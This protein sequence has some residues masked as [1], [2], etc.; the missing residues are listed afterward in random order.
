[1]DDTTDTADSDLNETN[2]NIIYVDREETKRKEFISP[3]QIA[4]KKSKPTEDPRLTDAYSVMTA[5][6]GNISAQSKDGCSAYTEHIAFKLRSYSS[7]TRAVVEHHINNIIFNADMGLY[8]QPNNVQLPTTPTNSVG[9]YSSSASSPVLSPAANTYQIPRTTTGYN[10]SA[11]SSPSV[12]QS[13]LISPTGNQV[14]IPAA[15]VYYPTTATTDLTRLDTGS[16]DNL[17]NN[18]VSYFTNYRN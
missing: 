8:A 1:M 5:L 10:S 13:P 12:T 7:Y 14:N 6:K 9:D 16:T 18:L 11:A 15:D 17:E 4:K 2:S 3:K